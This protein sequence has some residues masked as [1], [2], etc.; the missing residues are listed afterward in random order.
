M[1]GFSGLCKWVG[2][3]SDEWLSPLS[4]NSRDHINSCEISTTVLT[5]E[6]LGTSLSPLHSS[7]EILAA[8]AGCTDFTGSVKSIHRSRGRSSNLS[9]SSLPLAADEME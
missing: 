2:R 4:P 6:D 1:E 5:S 3:I 8:Y 9:Y 7:R